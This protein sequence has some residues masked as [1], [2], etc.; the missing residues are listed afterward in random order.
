MVKLEVNELCVMTQETRRK[1]TN[2]HRVVQKGR[3][4]LVHETREQKEEADAIARPACQKR[5]AEK[6]VAVIAKRA[7]IDARKAERARKAAIKRGDILPEEVVETVAE[8][9]PKLPDLEADLEADFIP[10]YSDSD[11]GISEGSSSVIF[12]L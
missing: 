4:I 8:D 7:T 2:R 1:K 6:K 9:E 10:I 12:K 11:N 3:K 5:I